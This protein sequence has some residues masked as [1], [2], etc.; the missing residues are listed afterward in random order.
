MT[1]FSEEH[2]KEY[3]Q[4][5]VTVGSV[6]KLHVKDTNPPKVKRFIVIGITS[7]KISLA[8]LYI[9]S[10]LNTSVNWSKE[11]QDLQ[12]EYKADNRDYLDDDSFVDCSKFNIKD[13][14]EIEKMIEDR[15]DACLGNISDIDLAQLIETIKGCNTIKG[16]HKKRF[17]IYDA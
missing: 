13:T 8:T 10:D 3:A 9:N 1:F 17:G 4:R 12:I 11:L 14:K 6:L 16:K 7:D 5:S 2:K 15:P